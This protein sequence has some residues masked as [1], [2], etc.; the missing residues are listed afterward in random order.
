VRDGWAFKHYAPAPHLS[1]QERDEAERWAVWEYVNASKTK[2]SRKQLDERWEAIRVG[3]NRLRW[4]VDEM[5]ADG[6]LVYAD[7]PR[8]ERRGQR[9]QYLKCGPSP[10]PDGEPRCAR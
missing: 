7:F 2:L 3:R 10:A 1:K 9:T 8:E 5:V 6:Q 4:V